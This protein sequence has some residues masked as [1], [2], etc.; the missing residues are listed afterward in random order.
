VRCPDAA[1]A[2]KMMALIE[3]VRKETN[4]I[5]GVA[6]LV[7]R[8]LPIGL[9]EP[10]FDKLRA[11]L[12]KALFSL[13]AVLGVEFGSGFAAAEMRGSEH[14]DIFISTNGEIQTKTNNHGGMLGGITSGMPLVCRCAIKPTSS[15][16]KAQ[17][18]VTNTGEKTSISTKGR[19]DPCLLPRFMPMA[20]AMVAITITDHM[21]KNKAQLAMQ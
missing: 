5:G 1:A 6:E 4:S 3:T 20:E 16:A 8:G 10:V 12:G 11:D 21:L 13:P 14:N 15:I 2:E 19:H 18:T 17:E 7:V 9:G